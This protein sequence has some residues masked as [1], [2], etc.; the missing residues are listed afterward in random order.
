MMKKNDPTSSENNP[1]QPTDEGRNRQKNDFTNEVQDEDFEGRNSKLA[2]GD[3]EIID[4]LHGRQL[5]KTS[6]NHFN[7]L[8]I[9]TTFILFSFSL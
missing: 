2:I 5:P 9:G 4:N 3:H 1:G 7:T 6:T 8:A